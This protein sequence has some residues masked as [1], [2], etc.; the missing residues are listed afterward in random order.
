V[1]PRRVARETPRTA[2]ELLTVALGVSKVAPPPRD[3]RFADPAWT[4]TP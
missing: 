1:D 4:E 2:R 3:A